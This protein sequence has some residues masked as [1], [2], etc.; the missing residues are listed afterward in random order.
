MTDTTTDFLVRLNNANM[1]GKK[2][3]VVPYSKYKVLILD[4]LKNE[5]YIESFFEDKRTRQITVNFGN[6]DR[7][8]DKIQVISKPGS[9]I[10]VKKNKIPRSKGGYGTVIIS[11]PK[12]VMT[13]KK[14]RS[15]GIGG[16]VVC[17]VY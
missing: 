6:N 1:S 2:T 16:E 11:T 12:G 5:K 15:A 8:F 7:H 14:A 9:K 3:I 17:E 13:D 10:Y 4:V